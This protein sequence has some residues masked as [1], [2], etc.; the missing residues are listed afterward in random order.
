MESP[1]RHSRPDRWVARGRRLHRA[2][3]HRRLAPFRPRSRPAP[4]GD[5]L[6]S[7]P[8]LLVFVT[9]GSADTGGDPAETATVGADPTGLAAVRRRPR[10]RQLLVVAL[11]VALVGGFALAVGPRRVA[12]ELAGLD[13]RW[14]AAAVAASLLSLAIWSEA[15]RALFTAAGATVPASRFL[16]AYAVGNFAKRTLP[17]GRLGAPAVMAYALGRETTIPYERGLTAVVIGYT[18]GFPAA[19]MVPVA[20]VPLVATTGAT[21]AAPRLVALLVAIAAVA[22]GLG[23]LVVARPRPPTRLLH[24]LAAAGRADSRPTVARPAVASACSRRVGGPGRAATSPPRPS[25]TAAT[26]TSRATSRGAA[27]VAPV[28]ATSGTAATGTTIAAGKPT[29]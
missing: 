18:V 26:A 21:S 17:G 25:A 10:A 5:G 24:A 27:L 19:I 13:P 1:V 4:T 22:L 12:S 8:S 9:N 29:V 20:A 3:D 23:G 6:I 15:Q 28:V 11:V 7:R 16:L 14:F 2:C